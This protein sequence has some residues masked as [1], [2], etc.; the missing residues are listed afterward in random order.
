MNSNDVFYPDMF[1]SSTERREIPQT[2]MWAV[3]FPMH[4]I[5]DRK[6][7]LT[8]ATATQLIMSVETGIPVV[9]VERV[10]NKLSVKTADDPERG[11]ETG[12]TE[13]SGSENAKYLVQKL[14]K[15][16]TAKGRKITINAVIKG[17]ITEANQIVLL[18]TGHPPLQFARVMHPCVSPSANNI[19]IEAQQWALLLAYGKR[20]M[21][22]VPSDIKMLL[23]RAFTAHDTKDDKFREFEAKVKDFF[24]IDKWVVMYLH[25]YGIILGK[26]NAAPLMQY[27]IEKSRTDL[28]KVLKQEHFDIRIP[29]KLYKSFNDI[30]DFEIRRQAL[31]AFVLAKNNRADTVECIDSEKLIPIGSIIQAPIGAISWRYYQGYLMM[32]DA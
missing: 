18:A 11:S 17:K 1:Q 12:W 28:G 31:A 15:L 8:H 21:V 2:Y 24:D 9:M 20:K 19:P 4:Y 10:G 27:A 13:V 26:I 5:F 16:R 7:F 32:V 14:S 30:P 3:A 29:F 22:E 23:D 25:N 6:L